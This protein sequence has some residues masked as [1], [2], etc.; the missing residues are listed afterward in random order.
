MYASAEPVLSP[1]K[2]RFFAR[3]ASETFLSSLHIEFLSNLLD[4]PYQTA[5]QKSSTILTEFS[6]F[7]LTS[8][9]TLRQYVIARSGALCSLSSNL[10]EPATRL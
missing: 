8:R 9:L 1:P 3:L 10:G 5:P 6:F 7:I 4:H 2:D